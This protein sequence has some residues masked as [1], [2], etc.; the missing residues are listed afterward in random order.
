MTDAFLY[1]G[2]SLLVLSR[3]VTQ[4][5]LVNEATACADLRV[6]CQAWNRE[7]GCVK[8]HTAV[9]TARATLSFDP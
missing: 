7:H 2:S 8:G 4:A 1:P 6:R 5:R 3:T 9:N